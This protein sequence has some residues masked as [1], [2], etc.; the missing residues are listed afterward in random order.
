MYPC[1]H[2]YF[3]FMADYY[4]GADDRHKSVFSWSI[5]ACG[6]L[7]KKYKK[8]RSELYDYAKLGSETPEAVVHDIRSD[9]PKA[10]G[11]RTNQFVRFFRL[12]SKVPKT[13]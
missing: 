7:L 10:T 1:A 3:S 13:V 8:P 9:H 5:L 12:F 2:Q 11:I 6:W 4:N